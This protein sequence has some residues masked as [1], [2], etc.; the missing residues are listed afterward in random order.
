M[1]RC[2]YNAASLCRFTFCFNRKVDVA[3]VVS[4]SVNDV[5]STLLV[6]GVP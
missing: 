6:F 5:S 3:S 1:F 4:A 2:L